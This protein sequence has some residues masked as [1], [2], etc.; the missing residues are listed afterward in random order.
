MKNKKGFT[1]VELIAVIAIL[2]VIVLVALP[3]VLGVFNKSIEEVMKIEETQATDAGSLYVRDHCGRTAKSKDD[4][5]KCRNDVTTQKIEGKVYF[6][7]S[8]IRKNGYIDEIKYKGNTSCDGIV[9][10]EYD[11]EE[12]TFSN[13]KTYLVCDNDL[14]I[15]PELKEKDKNN[16][17]NNDIFNKY[18]TI[19]ASC[20]DSSYEPAPEPDPTP[21]PEPT[22]PINS[23]YIVTLDNAG[24]T[25]T[26]N[27][28]I[29]LKYGEGWYS[30]SEG[31][32]LIEVVNIPIK[33]GNEFN[34]YYTGE[35]G[36][37]TK[38]IDENGLIQI[39]QEKVFNANG[40]LYASW[41]ASIY[42]LTLNNDGATTKGTEAIYEKYGIG[43]Y[44]EQAGTNALTSIVVPVKPGYIFNGYSVNEYK[45]INEN[46]VINNNTTVINSDSESSASYTPRTY[47]VILNNDGADI[48]GTEA[49]YLKYNT[50]WYEEKLAI[51]IITSI[52]NP[53]KIDYIFK[54]YYTGED[55]SGTQ[56]IDENG[57]INSSQTKIFS[58]EVNIG[59]LHAHWIPVISEFFYT[60]DVQFY[61]VPFTG[62]Y[63][64][65]VWGAQGGSVTYTGGSGGYSYGYKKLTSG[66]R[67][68]VYVG[69][70]GGNENSS[71]GTPGIGGYNGGGQGGKGLYTSLP[72]TGGG[73]GGGATHI[74]TSTGLLNELSDNKDSI[75]IVAGGGGGSGGGGG[76]CASNIVGNGGGLSGTNGAGSKAGTQ[77]SGYKFGQGQNGRDGDNADCNCEGNGG[78]GGGYYGGESRSSTGAF[79]NASGSGGSGYIGGV[80][81]GNMSTGVR[82]GNGYAVIKYIPD[83]N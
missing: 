33:T 61:T 52:T 39:G 57:N 22:T 60:G 14:Y 23:I 72:H 50:G 30:D 56:V 12:V 79:T 48:P 81:N 6:C 17:E 19:I 40:T 78:G 2:A 5:S 70:Q 44:S 82:Q 8:E 38:V 37:G 35:N 59:I 4:R 1:L 67:L 74:A 16:E 54:G 21:N 18:K 10:Y 36:T 65:E 49:I 73:G 41:R 51:N 46:G 29:Y 77:S 63:K 25:S 11:D 43:W 13:G 15:T 62:N 26:G 64:L 45:L 9:L 32:N 75:L 24:G 20:K 69:G 42:K 58:N 68:Y 53:Q 3:N 55:G 66:T 71:T 83:D 27:S 76:L 31:I 47:S 28:Q 80:S 34:G 7:L